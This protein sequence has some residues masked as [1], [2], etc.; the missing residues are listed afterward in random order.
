MALANQRSDSV[1]GGK[2][3]NAWSLNAAMPT[4]AAGRT[5]KSEDRDHRDPARNRERV[6]GQALHQCGPIRSS[7]RIRARMMARDASVSASATTERL[8]AKGKLKLVKPS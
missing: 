8:A 6:P 1:W 4:T 5:M 2:T 3:S 7:G